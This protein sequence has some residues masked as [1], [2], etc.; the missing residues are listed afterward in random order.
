IANQNLNPNGNGNVVAAWD[1]GNVIRNNE[2]WIQLQAEEFDFMAAAGDLEE[3]K[4][5]NANCILMANLQ[6]ALTSGSQTDKPPV[7]DSDRSTEVHHSENCYNNDIFNMFTQ[8]E[9]YTELLEL[10]PEP[11]QVQQN[12]SN[13]ITVVSNVEQS[14]GT[15]E[16]HHA[17]AEETRAL[18]DY[19][20]SNL[21]TK[22]ETVNSVNRNLKETNAELTTELARYKNQEK[23]FEIN[24]EKYENLK[25]VIKSLF[26]KSN[27]LLKR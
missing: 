17:T 2:A 9:Q 7:Y 25:G 23:C 6:Q 13:V 21:A 19:L 15:A 10:I 22:V 26:I 24:Q 1:E 27:V 3:I 5:V 14:G 4:E 11:H 8:E 20:Y 16:Q 18:Y 12:D